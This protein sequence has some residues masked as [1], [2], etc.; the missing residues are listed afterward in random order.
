MTN[1]IP[2]YRA[3]AAGGASF[4]GLSLLNQAKDIGEMI[5]EHGAKT[6]L[7][8]GAGAGDAYRSPHKVWRRWGVKW[9]DVT[10]YDPAFVE[11][12]T[13]PA[14]GRKFDGVICSDV[15]EH[16]P[17]E[18]VDA[19]IATLFDHARLFVWASVC[20]RPAKKS[21]PDGTNL[22]ENLDAWNWRLEKMSVK[23]S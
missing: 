20:C 22:V 18:D 15:L 19:V 6:L 12:D 8:Y 3:M 9:S 13:P 14:S 5:R 4:R 16:V 17:E 21:F 11:H 23:G 10:L 7:D 1:L 2:Q